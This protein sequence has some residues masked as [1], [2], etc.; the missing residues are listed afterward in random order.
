[1]QNQA[2][3]VQ[4]RQTLP[5]AHLG[6]RGRERYGFFGSKMGMSSGAQSLREY[7]P[8][9][10]HGRKGCH[11]YKHERRGRDNDQRRHVV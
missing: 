8:W 6:M 3:F 4:G 7:G 1:M 11:I 10:R 2:G 5:C 9:L